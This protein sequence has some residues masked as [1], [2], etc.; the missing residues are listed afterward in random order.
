MGNILNVPALL[1]A[2]KLAALMKGSTPPLPLPPQPRRPSLFFKSGQP[3]AFRVQAFNGG[4]LA[5]IPM[6]P[7]GEFYREDLG[8]FTISLDDLKTV[9]KNAQGR[10][11]LMQVDYMHNAWK[12]ATGDNVAEKRAAGWIDRKSLFIAKWNGGFCLMGWGWLTQEAADRRALGELLYISPAIEPGKREIGRYGQPAGAPIGLTIVNVAL[13]DVPFF[14]MPP[15]ALFQRRPVWRFQGGLGM[16]ALKKKLGEIFATLGLAADLIPAAVDAML[17]ELSAG[18]LI[19]MPTAAPA[20]LP[21]AAP[22]ADPAAAMQAQIAQAA[23][24]NPAVA[25]VFTALGLYKPPPTFSHPFL[26]ALAGLGQQAAPL[27]AAPAAHPLQALMQLLAPQPAAPA[28]HPL[29]ALMQLLQ[30]AAP[31][32]APV[33]PGQ[34]FLGSLGFDVTKLFSPTAAGV[35]TLPVNGQQITQALAAKGNKAMLLRQ[36]VDNYLA[37]ARKTRPA[38]E[39]GTAMTE[40]RGRGLLNGLEG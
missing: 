38:L 14:D 25:Q 13:C 6:C 22:A 36:T 1:T 29:Q 23:A 7:T 37:E 27:A 31:A 24:T 16:D 18:G 3:A 15:V 8:N 2:L 34:D 11:D 19:T 35:P 33:A 30:P 28:A 26:A 9:M 10:S 4:R 39:Y 40:L 21:A 17:Q 32:V 20:A 5:L 12:P